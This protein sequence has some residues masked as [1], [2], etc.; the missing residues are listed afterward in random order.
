MHSKLAVKENVSKEKKERHEKTYQKPAGGC[1]RT[2]NVRPLKQKRLE[3][4][5]KSS[6]C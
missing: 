6:E 1:A 2:T 3:E 4:W 5:A